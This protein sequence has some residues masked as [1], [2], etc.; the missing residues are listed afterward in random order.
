MHR[1]SESALSA[2][3]ACRYKGSQ[4]NL[5]NV[6]TQRA[7]QL[8]CICFFFLWECFLTTFGVLLQLI[9]ILFFAVPALGLYAAYATYG[10]Y[11]G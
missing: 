6:R 8:G 11:W 3:P 10:V 9:V 2:Y 5:L 1:G 4:V 7:Q